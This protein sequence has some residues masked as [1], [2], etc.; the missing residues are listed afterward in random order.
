MPEQPL[1]SIIM[2]TRDP[3][4]GFLREA[5]AS[6]QAQTHGH[7]ELIMVDDG[8]SPSGACQ[9]QLAGAKDSRI[10]IVRHRQNRRLPA[11][12]NTGIALAQGQYLTW[13][14]DDDCFRP[15]ALE[16]ML[17]FLKTHPQIHLVYCN[18]HLMSVDGTPLEPVRVG[19]VE[20]LGI[21][22]PVGICYLATR[23]SFASTGFREEF[24]L[25][26]DLDFWIRALMRY[27]AAPLH[28]D[29]ALYRQHGGTL[30]KTH[31]RVQVLN[32]H[33]RILDRH[34]DN[35]HWLDGKGRV[36]AYLR[37]TKGFLS[38]HALRPALSALKQAIAQGLIPFTGAL[39][40]LLRR[41]IG[42]GVRA[43]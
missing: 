14:S 31:T 40:D 43:S 3:K 27:R 16:R 6:C 26:E 12:L 28:E 18:Y 29:L 33:R 8:S 36:R 22:K 25:A 13:L 9:I 32:V 19:P 5:I 34:L 2:P 24:F 10:R 17:A 35:M 1:I 38:Q 21:H 11:A 42:S 7:W 20:E 41:R 37:L 39:G 23:E 15:R 30:T 4:P